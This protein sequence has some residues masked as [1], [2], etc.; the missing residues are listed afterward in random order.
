MGL[1]RSESLGKYITIVN[2]RLTVRV[3]DGTQGAVQRELTAGKNA[4]SMVSEMQ[5]KSLSG[6]IIGLEYSKKPLGD[7]SIENVE[8]KIMDD[9]E[10]ILQI[11]W[12]SSLKNS[13]L[14]VLPNVDYSKEVKFVVFPDKDTSKPVLLVCQGKNADGKD[15]LVPWAHTKDKPNG[16]P[17]AKETTVRGET[18]W[19]FSLVEEFLYELL[20]NEKKRIG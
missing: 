12:N 17:K 1:E 19:D 18:K 20:M 7:K 14:C 9:Q 11:S 16:M 10:Y 15:K 6:K 3:P 8:V 13:L 2:G 5:Y 4:G